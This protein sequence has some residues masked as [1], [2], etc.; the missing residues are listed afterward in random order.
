MNVN[1]LPGIGEKICQTLTRINCSQIIDLIFYLP[2]S[3]INYQ[4]NPSLSKVI[5]GSNIIVNVTI[6]DLYVPSKIIRGHKKTASKIYCSNDTG[7][8]IVTYFNFYPQYILKDLKVGDKRIIIGKAEYFNNQ[9]TINHPDYFLAEN[10]KQ[11]LPKIEP[12]YQ[13]TYGLNNK[14]LI[15]I[16]NQAILKLPHLEEWLSL[17][18]INLY[19]FPSFNEAIKNCHHQNQ[20]LK[21]D[22][23]NNSRLRLA[24]DELLAHQLALNIIRKNQVKKSKP[25]LRFSGDLQNQFLKLLPFKLTNNQQQAIKQINQDQ[26]SKNRM[27]RLLQGDVGS[28]KTVVAVL[29]MLN[30]VDAHKQACLM[31][32]TDIL[33]TQHFTWIKSFSS[34]LNIKIELLTGKIKGK[35]RANILSDL[36]LGKIDILIG[37]HALF[38]EVVIFKELSLVVIDEQHRFGVEQRL[39]LTSKGDNPDV[40]V[41][42]AT[43]IPRSLTLALYGDMDVFRLEEKPAE[44]LPIKT[45]I[46]PCSKTYDVINSLHKLISTGEKIY[47]ICPL[48][49]ESIETE[50]SFKKELKAVISRY[51]EFRA[52]FND[53]VSLIHGKMNVNDKDQAMKDFINGNSQILVA[54]TVIEV[55]IDVKDATIIVIEQAECFG[56]AQ[57]HQLRGRVG[58]GNKQSHCILLYSSIISNVGK[59]R[60]KIMR[61]SNDGFE[62]AER[63]L[64][65]RG[66]GEVLGTKQSG[67]TDFK[68]ADISI[69]SNL[70]T[71]ASNYAKNILEQDPNLKNNFLLKNLLYLFK[72][73]NCV[74]YFTS[75]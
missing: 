23:L 45:A 38:Q 54:T 31:A 42:S 14:H 57:L 4:I 50:V 36:E 56:L 61:N 53:K 55:G 12:V 34:N 40:L 46:I 2:V 29:A 69:H 47:W 43:P 15:K 39:A 62:I 19:N 22:D 20:D 49:D 65:L 1:S 58:R 52:I 16:I 18:I 17:D 48:V 13:L 68:F 33:A 51:N 71:H 30:V 21:S 9:L 44:R 60:L 25:L 6:D 75:G 63:D 64:E 41:M 70:F 37:T 72:Y 66:A 74:K 67:G 7:T 8:L 24:F 5:T 59:E 35:I 28:G 10:S 73:N 3:Y 26:L 32:P 11:I 27:M